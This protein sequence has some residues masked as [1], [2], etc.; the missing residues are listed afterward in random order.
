MITSS[1]PGLLWTGYFPAWIGYITRGKINA[2]GWTD[3]KLVYFCWYFFRNYS[4]ALLV[5]MSVEKCI[6]LYFPFKTRNI[7]TV[8]TAKRAS[9]IAFVVFFVLNIF[10]FLVVKQHRAGLG[11]F[12]DYEDYFVKYVLLHS[13]IDSIIYSLGPFFIMG[14]TNIAIIHKLVKAKLVSK[15]GRTESMNQALSNAT[16]RGTAILITVTMTFIILTGPANI[17]SAITLDIHPLL[18]PFLYIS[19]ALNH[20]INGLL[21]TIVG[22]KF[23]KELIDTLRC[24]RRQVQ[25]GDGGKSPQGSN[26]SN[27]TQITS[28]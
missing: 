9:A 21:Y 10:W 1:V 7:C 23:R 5:M 20:S 6:A 19:V 22:S 25:S 4:S 11:Y 28:P 15:H 17:I 16:M 13:L 12:C 27:I 8:K 14:L 24:R 3:C 26:V 18:S 2:Y